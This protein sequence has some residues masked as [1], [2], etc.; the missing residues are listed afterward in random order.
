MGSSRRDQAQKKNKIRRW[1]STARG[2]LFFLWCQFCTFR[3]LDICDQLWFPH[4]AV[5]AQCRMF[6]MLRML[7][8]GFYMYNR[9]RVWNA[10]TRNKPLRQFITHIQQYIQLFVINLFCFVFYIAYNQIKFIRMMGVL[11]S[12]EH[13]FHAKLRS[14]GANINN[15]LF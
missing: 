14:I 13:F 2:S 6:A 3:P 7:N 8:R 1:G 12:R 10:S 15:E 9:T 11:R 5:A 4:A